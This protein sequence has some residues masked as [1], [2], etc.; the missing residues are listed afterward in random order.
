MNHGSNVR[1]LVVSVQFQNT[2]QIL[3]SLDDPHKDIFSM[4]LAVFTS[5]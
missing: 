1:V 4:D 2:V 3:V 5:V